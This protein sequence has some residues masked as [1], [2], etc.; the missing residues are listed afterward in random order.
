MINH[1]TKHRYWKLPD[2][3]GAKP[4]IIFTVTVFVVLASLDNAAMG[5]LPPLYSVI[6]KDL[7]TRE[8][9]LGLSG[10]LTV[11]V[12]AISA[13]LW[14]YLG[15]RGKRKWVILYGTGI[16]T[17]GTF[18][19]G[20]STSISAFMFFQ[21]V[22]AIGIGCIASVGFSI[23]SDFVTS[24][25]RGLMMS[26]WGLSQGLGMGIG[27]YFGGQL[28][29]QECRIPFYCLA[30]SGIVF[31]VL[32]L[33]TYEPKR[34]RLDQ[35]QSSTKSN[36]D[37]IE[38]RIEP[39]DV[40]TLITKPSNI[41]L[42]LQ[43]FSAQLSYGSLIWMP[44]LYASK[45][46]ALGYSLQ[47]AT[48]VGGLFALLFQVGGI[49]SI[50][51]GYVGDIW[52]K[53]DPRGRAMVSCLGILG[54]IPPFIIVFFIPLNG[55]DIPDQGSN[56]EIFW[57]VITNIFTNRWVATAFVLSLA[58]M[59]LTS[60]DSPNWLALLSEV[61]LPEHRGT[62]FGL[63]NL[64]NGVGRAMGIWLT[65]LAAS[66]FSTGFVEPFNYAVGLTIFQMF[67]LPAGFCYYQ[68]SKT[69]PYDTAQTRIIL[70]HRS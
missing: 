5:I 32:Y 21:L 36:M 55:L 16:W 60:A 8:T 43:G 29:A 41:W 46:E 20:I 12:S 14:G 3:W 15:D 6:A 44:R 40:L 13:V 68:A 33:F 26:L 19:S 49:L 56:I 35:I 28:G 23:L 65:P 51:G 4:H 37:I 10:A 57:A 45:A 64:S 50:L 48:R 34:G 25:R 27:I 42:I 38:P 47:T 69:T 52:Q 63:A 66:F 1:S 61:N 7:M 39:R 58:A 18:L 2:W 24:Q 59:A 70:S 9:I 67:F 53:R 22:T 30:G 17:I 54:A 31:G 62:A 11:F